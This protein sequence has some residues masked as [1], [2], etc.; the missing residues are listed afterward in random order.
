MDLFALIFHKR[1]PA[2]RAIKPVSNM[3]IA[4]NEP[5]KAGNKNIIPAKVIAKAP[6]SRMPRVIRLCPS[7]NT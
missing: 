5:I 6:N 3:A 2:N 7:G 4:I 1:Y